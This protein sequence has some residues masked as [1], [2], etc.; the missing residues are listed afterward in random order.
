ME[1]KT[2]KIVATVLATGMLMSAGI[3]AFAAE[4]PCETT[5]NTPTAK[6]EIVMRSISYEITGNNV[7]L[8]A[9]PSLSGDVID[10]LYKGDIVVDLKNTVYADGHTWVRVQ[11]VNCRNAYLNGTPAWVASDY[12]RQVG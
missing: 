7:R 4:V 10:Y 2:K 12:L 6:S 9:T 3:P 8:R 11:C 1:H 5:S